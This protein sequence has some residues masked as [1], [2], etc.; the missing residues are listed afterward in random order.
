MLRVETGD[1]NECVNGR[2]QSNV[3]LTGYYG[4]IFCKVAL[5]LCGCTKS[6]KL[7]SRTISRDLAN[8]RC[9]F[10]SEPFLQEIVASIVTLS[11]LFGN[12]Y[13]EIML[14]N[15]ALAINMWDTLNEC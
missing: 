12:I 15:S 11:I 8:S 6:G 10:V 2:E 13:V 1:N 5:T 14:S 3:H 4:S 9:L 7:S